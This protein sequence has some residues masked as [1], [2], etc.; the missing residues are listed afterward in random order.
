MRKIALSLLAHPD[1]AEILCAG[2]LIRLQQL[3]WD[4][5]IVTVCK[6]DLGTATLSK[7]EITRIRAA[8]CKNAVAAIGAQHHSLG[9][10]DGF[11]TFDKSTMRKTYDLF[12]IINPG[13]VFAHPIRDYM[14]DH[15]Q[16]SLLARAATFLYAAR[17]ASDIPV[18]KGAGVPWLYYC[19]PIGGVDPFGVTVTPTTVID[20]T[21]TQD[22]KLQML[23]C[24]SSQ[25]EWLAA[26]HGMDE[27]IEATRRHDADRGTL[28][29][30]PAAEAFVQHRGHAYPEA[31]LLAELLK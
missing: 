16:V 8:E 3:G 29:G 20:I 27:Y 23:A 28:I 5:H 10:P 25:R 18:P 11:V 6:G 4:I 7:D 15:E 31:D 30:K 26:H 22:R 17:N 24:H 1:D 21:S 2:T 19:D 9:E 12:R 13:L 14:L